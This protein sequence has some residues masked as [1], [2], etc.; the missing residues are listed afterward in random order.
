MGLFDSLLG[1]TN[2][3][4]QVTENS[5]N[6]STPQI[7]P[8]NQTLPSENIIGESSPIS[9]EN[10]IDSM[11][12]TLSPTT[13]DTLSLMNKNTAASE[14]LSSVLVQQ[15][16]Q[17]SPVDAPTTQISTVENI[18]APQVIPHTH[19]GTTT[20]HHNPIIL[21]NNTGTIQNNHITEMSAPPVA[22]EASNQNG[23]LSDHLATPD[24]TSFTTPV[25]S[26]LPDAENN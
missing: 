25:S 23:V 21:E 20:E 11:M 6:I 24:T 26:I 14:D 13:N 1:N 4:Q 19:Q 7:I 3:M 22:T 10:T 8:P 17:P 12:I 9:P 16:I 15:D 2:T 18:I 5:S